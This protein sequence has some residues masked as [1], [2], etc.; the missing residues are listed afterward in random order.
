MNGLLRDLSQSMM[1]GVGIDTEG[2][3]MTDS[4]GPRKLC[5]TS[6]KGGVGK[7]TLTVNL[8]YALA[9]DGR[10][11]L[12]VDGDL[13]LANVDVLLGL[14]VERTIRD[15]LDGGADPLESVVPVSERV[16][17]LPASSGVPD[18]VTLSP[19]EQGQLEAVLQTIMEHYDYVL[20]DTAAGIGPS[21]LW[22]NDFAD[23]T[24]VVTG[25]DPAS[26]TDAYA[27]IKVLQ[28]EYGRERFHVI[29]NFVTSDREARRIQETLTGVTARFLGLRP[30][31][32]GGILRDQA[33][34]QAA[35]AQRP[36]IKQYPDH[37]A[38]RSI[39]EVAAAI[40]RWDD[41]SV[42]RNRE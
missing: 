10:K 20:L 28:R 7:T 38:A 42:S 26:L 29:V 13:G 41:D 27:L 23:H 17:V 5:I 3:K 8:A 35:R 30:F 34:I 11:V 14:S 25:P 9:D 33:V 39:L 18:M 19:Q 2:R 4:K 12:I 21:V 24:I 15:V 37:P 16:D 22:F 31:Y 6:G 36:F 40:R 1:G 32:L